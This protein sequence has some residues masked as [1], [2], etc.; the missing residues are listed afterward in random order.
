MSEHYARASRL[1][2]RFGDR[3]LHKV[4]IVLSGR[5]DA[6]FLRLMALVSDAEQHGHAIEL[7]APVEEEE[8]EHAA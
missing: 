4:C 6:E 5:N 7:R 1:T 2:I 8:L 3:E